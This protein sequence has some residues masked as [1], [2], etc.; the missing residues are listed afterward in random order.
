MEELLLE[1][2]EKLRFKDEILMI[3]IFMNDIFC[4]LVGYDCVGKFV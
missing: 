3:I 4:F 2:L 1:E